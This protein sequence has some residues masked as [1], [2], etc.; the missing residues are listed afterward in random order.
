MKSLIAVLFTVVLIATAMG[1]DWKIHAYLGTN[2]FVGFHRITSTTLEHID[3]MYGVEPRLWEDYWDGWSISRNYYWQEYTNGPVLVLAESEGWHC[4]EIPWAN[5][6]FGWASGSTTSFSIEDGPPDFLGA[7]CQDGPASS[8]EYWID[9]DP[10]AV[11]TIRVS[12]SEPEEFGKYLSTG[13]LNPYWTE[14]FS[15][16]LHGKRLAKGHKK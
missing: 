13:L 6:G 15:F 9:W 11:G 3:L 14:P 16:I 12:S 7:G 4:L 2:P 8:G 10:Y 5:Y 1:S